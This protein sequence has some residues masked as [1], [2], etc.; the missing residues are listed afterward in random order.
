MNEMNW[1]SE[2]KARDKG[3]GMGMEKRLEVMVSIDE[4]QYIRI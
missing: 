1:E 2:G 4:P 3:K